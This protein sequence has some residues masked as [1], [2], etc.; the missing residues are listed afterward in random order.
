MGG[1]PTPAATGS[2]E[3][4][5]SAVLRGRRVPWSGFMWLPR[6]FSFMHSELQWSHLHGANVPTLVGFPARNVAGRGAP[7][8]LLLLLLLQFNTS[9]LHLSTCTRVTWLLGSSTRVFWGFECTV[10]VLLKVAPASILLLLLHS[11][12]ILLLHLRSCPVSN[13]QPVCSATRV[14]LANRLVYL[15][16]LWST[17]LV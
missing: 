10:P 17:A 9:I 11:S 13:A 3:F 8:I 7:A 5:G 6:V 14:H 4:D 15:G 1:I 16:Q 2:K 12:S